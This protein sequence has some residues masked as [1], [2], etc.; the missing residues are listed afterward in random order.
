M[1]DSLYAPSLALLTDLYQLTMGYGYWRNQIHERRAVFHLFFRQCPFGGDYAIAAGLEPAL[2]WLHDFQVE[3]ED[4]A[5]LRT[6]CGNDG[7]P[8]F[9]EDFLE[10][11]A[12]MKLELNI[13]AIREGSIVFAHQPLMRIE[14][15]LWHCQWVETALLNLINFQTLIATKAARVCAAAQGDRVLEF[16]LRRAQGI[17]GALSASRASFIGGCHAT[18]NV[19]AGR[20]YGI[21]VA[22]THAH[23]WVMSFDDERT[24]FDAYANAL[25]NNCVFLVDTYDTIQGVDHAIEI[26]HQ[27]R[28]RGHEMI[29]IR[30]DSGDLADLSIRARQ[31]LDQ[32]GFPDALIVASND[33]DEHE[34]KKLKQKHATI[35]VWGV[36]TNL[37]TARD[38]P[39]LGGVYKLGA[40]QD[41]HNQWQPRIKLSELPIKTSTP[42][43]QQV[44]R[45]WHDNQMVGDVIYSELLG[46]P[47]EGRVEAFGDQNEVVTFSNWDRSEDLLQP[48]MRAGKIV[49]QLPSLTNIQQH[50]NAQKQVWADHSNYPQGL[51]PKLAEQKRNMIAACT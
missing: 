21:P 16:G 46:P 11:L 17:D 27:L 30:L 4:V 1:T 33:L 38:Q 29:G 44:R 2:Q 20:L 8:L 18:S 6:L 42:G 51:D 5:Y 43:I 40:I 47:E 50:A 34:I 41:D 39:A 19:M 7:K 9:S 14:G 12:G 3:A 13:D 22:G 25:P 36:G 37:V 35:A 24:A 28:S 31:R 26:G 32:Q 15:P 48:V 10:T 23:S 45:Y 49:T